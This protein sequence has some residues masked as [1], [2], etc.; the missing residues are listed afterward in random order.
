MG[1]YLHPRDEKGN[2]RFEPPPGVTSS[3]F[4]QFR[5]YCLHRGVTDPRTVKARYDARYGTGQATD[6]GATS[7]GDGGNAVR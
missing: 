6:P 1:V 7:P 2:L 5:R 3:K 4:E